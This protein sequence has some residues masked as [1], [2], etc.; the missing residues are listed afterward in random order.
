MQPQPPPHQNY[1]D[2]PRYL[3]ESL[4]DAERMLKYA[5]ESG[6]AVEDEV[7][8]HILQARAFSSSGW[9]AETGSSLLVALS[10]LAAKLKPVTAESLKLW[11]PEL[12]VQKYWVIAVCLAAI[13]VPFSV[14]SFVASAVSNTIKTDIA[15]ANDLAV[16][17]R[18]QL[19]APP[20]AANDD[21]K[22]VEKG[23]DS[24]KKSRTQRRAS[25]EKANA[26]PTDA[27]DDD[28]VLKQPAIPATPAAAQPNATKVIA[29]TA[30]ITELQQFA[31][32][33][34]EID[35]GAR[36]LNWLLFYAE[37]DPISAAT[38][39]DA[40]ALHN[41]FQLPDGLTDFAQA[42]ADR[43][44]VYQDV[45]YFG[46]SVVDDVAVFYGAIATC[47]LP[48][49]YALLGTCAFLSRNFQQQI[50]TRTYTRSMDAPRFLIAAIGGAVVGLFNNFAIGQGVTIPPLA[51]AF[52]VGYAVDVFFSFLEGLTQRFSKMGAA[53]AA[54]AAPTANGGKL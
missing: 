13:I 10:K 54:T 11:K 27:A 16:K 33:I 24:A 41:L 47:I 22:A 36:Q 46:Q 48:V 28:L 34:R 20:V 31:N 2:P 17:L 14:A 25:S 8:D 32:N 40:K 18:A 53:S 6:I 38:R 23:I 12:A 35:G 9:D 37:K 4:E 5:S 39:K 21:S 50:S 1:P 30:V 19:G 49:L 51:I 43:I 15:S 3:E 29:D 26:A 45:R 52:L 44:N 7:R 42:A